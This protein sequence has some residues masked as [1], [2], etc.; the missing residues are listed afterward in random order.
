[1]V[2]RPI[3]ISGMAYAPTNEQNAVFLFGRLRNGLD[4]LL[5]KLRHGFQIAQH[6]EKREYAT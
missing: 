1:M 3:N 4:L 5:S 2:S 6:D